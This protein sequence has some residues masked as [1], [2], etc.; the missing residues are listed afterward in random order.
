MVDG[1][2][3]DVIC[4]GDVCRRVTP[5]EAAAHA[6]KAGAPEPGEA[7]GVPKVFQLLGPTLL[8]KEG[9]EVPLSSVTGP[10]KVLGL[11]FSA[12][13]CPPCQHFTPELARIYERFR[14]FHARKEDWSVVFVSSDRDEDSFKHYFE[15]MPWLALPFAKREA[16]MELS[17][18]YKVRGIPTLIILD[19]ETG[20]LI[21]ADGR[22]AV[23][24]D[25]ECAGFPW[26]PRS[27]EEIMAGA[28]LQD[29]APADPRPVPA[30]ERIKGKVTLLYF[31]ASWC[32]PCRRF[33]PKLVETYKAL[34]AAGKDFEAVLVS[35]DREA[36][37]ATEYHSHMAWPMIPYDDRKTASEL[38]TRFGVEGIPTLVVLDEAG[39]VITT[40]G[41]A[42]VMADPTGARFPWR[43]QP[44]EALS[45]YTA[46]RIN[47][48][49]VLLLVVDE[50]DQAKAEEAATAA[51]G[52]VATATK[53][54]PGG[55]D[56]AFLYARRGDE[57]CQSVLHFC[58]LVKDPKA[59]PPAGS[60]LLLLDVP[61]SQ[62]VW[63]LTAAGYEATEAGCAKAVAD[64]KAKKLGPGKKL[65]E[66]DDE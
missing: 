32:P 14:A 1:K 33:T 18:L 37:A 50:E 20:E 56:W 52:P 47:N 65:G 26:K 45:P 19:G 4:E 57:M 25:D 27:F 64:R 3:D 36:G 60:R 16:K 5:E 58:G 49:A 54:A 34:K 24:E 31:S 8:G 22:D 39:Q 62:T 28:S 6:A 61:G 17:A 29:P 30:L 40:E 63:D 66:D 53:A 15:N 2:P 43:P 59:E 41:A 10:G 46:P 7:D 42:A 23:V 11:Y 38:N 55:D 48:A 12:H 35:A 13:W 44:L 9:A 21:T 51:L